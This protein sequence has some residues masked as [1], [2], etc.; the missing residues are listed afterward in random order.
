MGGVSRVRGKE[1]TFRWEIDAAHR[2]Q[3]AEMAEAL[4]KPPSVGHQYLEHLGDTG[5][6][7]VMLSCGERSDG[8]G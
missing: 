5:K 4:S 3:F 1:G 7:T 8:L 2:E 6:I